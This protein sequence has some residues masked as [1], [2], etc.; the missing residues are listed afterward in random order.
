METNV[1]KP[2][3]LPT[4]ADPLGSFDPAAAWLSLPQVQRDLIGTLAVRTAFGWFATENGYA[5]EDRVLSRDVHEQAELE[6]S[7][8][9]DALHDA[10]SAA[11]P[12]VF[13]KGNDDPAWI[14]AAATDEQRARWAETDE[15]FLDRVVVKPL[16]NALD[17]YAR[18]AENHKW[19][20]QAD[21]SGLRL[22]YDDQKS[23]TTLANDRRAVR[24]ATAREACEGARIPVRPAADH[25]TDREIA[26]AAINGLRRVFAPS[27]L[28]TEA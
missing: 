24:V 21:G 22:A 2:L 28:L 13:G 27:F 17:P 6:S 7:S 25:R 23:N 16:L 12:D 19:K 26:D 8:C 11:L 18:A 14:A 9:L 3:S 1:S 10:V 20:Q 15:R 4:S 5:E